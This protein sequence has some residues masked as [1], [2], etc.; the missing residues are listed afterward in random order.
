MT[1]S[2]DLE[3]PEIRSLRETIA[4]GCRILA[5]LELVDYLGHVSARV[6]G[7][8]MRWI[9][10]PLAATVLVLTLAMAQP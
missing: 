4:L 3:A 1:A 8:S 10:S 9:G 5:K 2:I 7:S 6:P